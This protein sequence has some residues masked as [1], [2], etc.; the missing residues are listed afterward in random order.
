MADTTTNTTTFDSL[1]NSIGDLA[2]GGAELVKRAAQ[3]D[4]IGDRQFNVDFTREKSVLEKRVYIK[5]P[6]T[7][8]SLIGIGARLS[9][10]KK[11]WNG[12][13]FPVTPSIKQDSSA[14]W[15]PTPVMHSNYPVYSY[16]G[17]DPGQISITGDFP[18]Q[19]EDEGLYY[20][21]TIHVLR[22]L[23]KMRTGNDSVP[24]APPPVCKLFAHGNY[25]FQDVPVVITSFTIN[26][27]GDVD[28]ISVRNA[29]NGEDARV[30]VLSQISVSL[31]PVYS[32]RQMANFSVEQFVQGYGGLS[33][34][35][36][37]FI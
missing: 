13:Y 33:G 32:R 18:V 27:P 2:A 6:E 22:A 23:T 24:G 19:N 7:Y 29:G 14:R 15:T 9:E 10:N 4:L 26:L 25:I 28:Y 5:I 12:I 37:G 1:L 17:S 8:R 11:G 36:K 31:A 16:S 3:G 21:S 30:P 20:L 34:N 35:V